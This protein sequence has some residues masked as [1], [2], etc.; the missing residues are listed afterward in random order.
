MKATGIVRKLDELGRVVV[1][2]EIRDTKGWKQ[3]T[4][5][6]MFVTEDSVVMKAYQTSE[7]KQD[8]LNTLE[9]VYSEIG[10]SDERVKEEFADVI[11]RIEQ[12]L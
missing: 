2:K 5:L 4:P 1:P 8:I 3:G 12:R 9:H 11:R 10:Q 7:D 6:E